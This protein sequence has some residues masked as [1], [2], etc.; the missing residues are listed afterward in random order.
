MR[1][2]HLKSVLSKRGCEASALPQAMIK[3]IFKMDQLR[4]TDPMAAVTSFPDFRSFEENSRKQL[5]CCGP[6]KSS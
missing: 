6:P 3:Q 1:N 5:H 4:P 2:I